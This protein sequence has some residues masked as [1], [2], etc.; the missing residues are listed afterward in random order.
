[1]E[2]LVQAVLGNNPKCAVEY[3]NEI[4]DEDSGKLMK[5]RQLITHPK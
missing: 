5:N 4:F 1:M 2:E 3:A